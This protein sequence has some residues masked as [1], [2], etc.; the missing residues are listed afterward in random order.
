MTHLRTIAALL[1]LAMLLSCGDGQKSTSTVTPESFTNDNTSSSPA[2]DTS[3][4]TTANR[5][6]KDSMDMDHSKSMDSLHQ[7]GNK[8]DSIVGDT[9]M[10]KLFAD[11]NFTENQIKQ[12][13]LN[14]H[15]NLEAWRKENPET[16]LTT[17]QRMRLEAENVKSFLKPAQYDEYQ[18]WVKDNPYHS[19]KK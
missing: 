13:R 2:S 10:T 16:S 5:S 3:P 12:F 18:R 4:D 6:S 11:L 15:K 8:T 17:E 1:F 7:T 19:G 14:V 9:R